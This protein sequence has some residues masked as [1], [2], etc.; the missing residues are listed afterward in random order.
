MLTTVYF[1]NN[2]LATNFF[3]SIRIGASFIHKNNFTHVS[4]NS[5]QML[6]ESSIL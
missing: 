4:V 2:S 5:E 6:A 1:Q 3:G